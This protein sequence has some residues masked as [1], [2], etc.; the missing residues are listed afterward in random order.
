MCIIGPVAELVIVYDRAR[1]ITYLLQRASVSQ[2]DNAGE[3]WPERSI[4]SVPCMGPC[5][6]PA[7][8]S[9]LLE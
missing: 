2:L 5:A 4:A 7:L 6:T 8:V 1:V 3:V 9:D